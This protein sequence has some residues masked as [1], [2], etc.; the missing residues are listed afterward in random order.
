MQAVMQALKRTI[1]KTGKPPSAEAMQEIEQRFGV[2]LKGRADEQHQ[3]AEGTELL[4]EPKEEGTLISPTGEAS[5]LGRI[6]PTM[7]IAFTCTVCDKRQ[8]KSM[9]KKSYESGVVLITC[10]GCKNRHLIADN[11]GWFGDGN[12]NIETILA[13]KGVD[14]RKFQEEG[15]IQ[16]TTEDV[17]DLELS[18]AHADKRREQR[19]VNSAKPRD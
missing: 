17:A 8:G 19:E 7:M 1:E 5:S 11:L 16:L 3:P 13:E 12:S 9:S 15:E 2:S 18:I 10:D 4:E 6:E 14:V